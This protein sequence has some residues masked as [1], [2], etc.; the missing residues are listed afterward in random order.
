MKRR[1]RAISLMAIGGMLA[2]PALAQA[3]TESGLFLGGGRNSAF[4]SSG[5]RGR[6]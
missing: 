2:L 6:R 5:P 4:F 3:D 1:A